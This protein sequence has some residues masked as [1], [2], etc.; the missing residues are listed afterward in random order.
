M[1]LALLVLA[2][3][4]STSASAGTKHKIAKAKAIVH[5]IKPKATPLTPAQIIVKT[6]PT[7]TVVISRRPGNT[8]KT[9]YLTVNNQDVVLINPVTPSTPP[10]NMHGGLPVDESTIP[11]AQAGVSDVRLTNSGTF[12]AK[13][14]E[15]PAGQFRTVCYY[16]HYGYDDPIVHPGEK[17]T[18][19]LHVF[20]G[21]GSTDY[22]STLNSL[23]TG[24]ST[25]R[26]G[27][28]IAQ[29]IGN[30]RC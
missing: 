8:N 5:V 13:S 6:D 25:C 22:N 17:G 26:G 2:V 4:L 24:T 18:S 12:P 3:C 27:T 9:I 30:Q 1:K 14:A 28:S 10:P 16:S 21:T 23:M 19:H 20:N 7:V 29:P 15:Y 11:V